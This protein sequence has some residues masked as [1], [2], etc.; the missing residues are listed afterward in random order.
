MA[1]VT[2]KGNP[3]NTLGNLPEVG[4]KAPNFQLAKT[5]LSNVTLNDYLGSKLI[6]NIFHSL[7]TGTCAQSVRQFNE[8]ARELENTK[9]LGISK[10][11]PFAQPR[12][13]GAE[14]IENVEQLNKLKD[15]GVDYG[16]GYYWS[17]P[18]PSDQYTELLQKFY[19][20]QTG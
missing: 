16:Q 7:D 14:G 1:Q 20:Q 6:L 18:K 11:L 19:N 12:F 9:V 4:S 13:C 10:D 15:L 5:D 8:E 2:L 3:I 17:P